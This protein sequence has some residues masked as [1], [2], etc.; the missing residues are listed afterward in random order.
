MK[1]ICIKSYESPCGHATIKHI[2]G[3]IYES[4]SDY[5][6]HII[7]NKSREITVIDEYGYKYWWDEDMINDYFISIQDDREEKLKELGI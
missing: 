4:S 2:K 7:D 3:N 6:I 5:F 1:L